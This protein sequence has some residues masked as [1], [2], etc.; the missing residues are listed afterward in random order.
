MI[1]APVVSPV[2]FRP[3]DVSTLR[4]LV[5]AGEQNDDRIA[6]ASEIDAEAWPER[7]A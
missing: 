5:T 7:D 4:A 2:L 3:I 6:F 1:S